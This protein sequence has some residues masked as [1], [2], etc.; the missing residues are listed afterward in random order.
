MEALPC[1]LRRNSEILRR[2]RFRSLPLLL[3]LCLLVLSSGSGRSLAVAALA[4]DG[5]AN[6]EQALADLRRLQGLKG[7]YAFRAFK[8]RVIVR[9]NQPRERVVIPVRAKAHKAPSIVQAVLDGNDA[10]RKNLGTAVSPSIEVFEGR[11]EVA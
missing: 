1:G 2:A 8:D 11:L 10:L 9:D 4:Q 7:D 3:P 6:Q 5:S